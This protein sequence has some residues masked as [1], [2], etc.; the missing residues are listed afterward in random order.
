[1]HA[2]GLEAVEQLADF[3]FHTPTVSIEKHPSQPGTFFSLATTYTIINQLTHLDAPNTAVTFGHLPIPAY[4]YHHVHALSVA[5]VELATRKQFWLGFKWG[6]QVS[7]PQLRL[8]TKVRAHLLRVQLGEVDL[9]GEGWGGECGEGGGG[10][11][12]GRDG[13]RGEESATGGGGPGK[14]ATG[15]SEGQGVD[16]AHDEGGPS[17]GRHGGRDGGRSWPAEV[18]MGTPCD[19]Y[20]LGVVASLCGCEARPVVRCRTLVLHQAYDTVR[21]HVYTHIHTHT[22]THTQT[23]I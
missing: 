14:Q 3:T 18:I 6:T 13:G 23:N 5:L 9:R 12:G 4:D 15:G 16:G 21:E 11:D 1:M 22:H 2:Q 10:R 8:A 7:E 19:S 20:T 17:G